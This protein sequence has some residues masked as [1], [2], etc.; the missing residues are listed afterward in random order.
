MKRKTWLKQKG[1][2]SSM[3]SDMTGLKYPNVLKIIYNDKQ[4]P[5]AENRQK[6]L[7]AFSDFPI[8]PDD[9]NNGSTSS[10]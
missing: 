10:P 2:T 1:L 4:V 7:K 3:F 5:N 8:I 9:K 6:I